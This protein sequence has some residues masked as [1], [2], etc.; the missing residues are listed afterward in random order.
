MHLG[1]AGPTIVNM[2]GACR[3]DLEVVGSRG[4]GMYEGLLSGSV[5][6]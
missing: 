6:D 5:S 3:V 4:L 2:A 1:H